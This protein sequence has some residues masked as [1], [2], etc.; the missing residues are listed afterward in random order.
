MTAGFWFSEAASL[1]DLDSHPN[2]SI[3]AKQNEKE[4]NVLKIISENRL[5]EIFNKLEITL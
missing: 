2:S 4:E 5:I 3:K 1:M